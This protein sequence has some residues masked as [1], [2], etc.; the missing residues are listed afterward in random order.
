MS[1]STFDP[2]RTNA[3][4]DS[5]PLGLIAGT[6]GGGLLFLGMLV[7]LYYWIQHRRRHRR[8][9]LRKGPKAKTFWEAEGK[10]REV[11]ERWDKPELDATGVVR[12][13]GI[14]VCE[15]EMTVEMRD[16]KMLAELDGR[17][18]VELDGTGLVE[19]SVGESISTT[20]NAEEGLDGGEKDGLEVQKG[21]DVEVEKMEVK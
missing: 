4:P 21:V 8:V 20:K 9:R 1:T 2:Y 17:E 6:I 10:V 19:M 5:L 3:T 11:Q 7:V 15:S 12:D 13:R 18:C 16:V 14:E